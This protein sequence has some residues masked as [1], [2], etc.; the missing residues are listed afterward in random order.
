MRLGSKGLKASWLRIELRKLE[1]LP[2]GEHWG[3]LIGRG[4]I[5]VW[6]AK[7]GHGGAGAA[8]GIGASGGGGHR[9]FG[10]LAAGG[11]ALGGSGGG[12]GNGEMEE[13]W[14]LLQNAD[15]PF[16]VLIPEGL[17]PS[18]KLDKQCE[19]AYELVT[20]LCVKSKKGIL[21]KESVSSIIQSTHSIHL[22]KHELHSLWP[23]YHC[24]DDHEMTQ[25]DVKLK[26]FRQQTCYGPGDS[27][28]VRVVVLS[29]NVNPMKLKSISF[30][31]KET[32]TF[33]GANHAPPIGPP[34]MSGPVGG[35]ASQRAE[36]VTGKGRTLGK[37]IFKGD[38]QMYD[39]SAVLSK[40][41]SLMTISTAKHI[42]VSYT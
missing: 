30:S 3:E 21:R 23:M 35:G 4:P 29:N 42:E 39:L 20:S 6:V 10:S 28:N 8:G 25:D 1:S 32:V 36:I 16:R 22:D 2:S 12:G 5:D 38:S 37:K 26:V 17:P 24:A 40:S 18:A 19:I 7:H 9:R 41:H 13:G 14:E 33:K 11:I 34:G 15:F 27:I 31:I